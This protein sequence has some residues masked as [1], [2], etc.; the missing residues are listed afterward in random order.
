METPSW[1]YFVEWLEENKKAHLSDILSGKFESDHEGYLNA[2][3]R[4][5]AYDEAILA[6]DKFIQEG[7]EAASKLEKNYGT[8]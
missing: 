1:G 3:A 4:Y 6:P 8:E 7:I 2:L 5:N